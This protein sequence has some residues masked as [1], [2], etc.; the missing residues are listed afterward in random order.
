MATGLS[1]SRSGASV[2]VHFIFVWLLFELKTLVSCVVTLETIQTAVSCEGLALIS[3]YDFIVN[4]SNIGGK[5]ASL[6]PLFHMAA[7]G[8]FGVGLLWI[9]DITKQWIRCNFDLS[10]DE[11]D[12]ICKYFSLNPFFP[13]GHRLHFPNSLSVCMAASG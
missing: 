8:A 3:M 4:C 1:H 13:A 12:K 6:F 9:L 5:T 11:S 10:F 7:V 2:V